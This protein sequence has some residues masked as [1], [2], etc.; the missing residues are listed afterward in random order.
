[1]HLEAPVPDPRELNPNIP[2]DVAFMVGRAMTKHPSS[3]QPSASEFY[4]ELGTAAEAGYGT[5]WESRSSLV[6]LVGPAAAAAAAAGAAVIPAVAGGIDASAADAT[7]IATPPVVGPAEQE[8]AAVAAAPAA[9][10]APAPPAPAAPAPPAT[11]VGAT[12]KR[13]RPKLRLLRFVLSML[14]AAGLVLGGI[15]YGANHGVLPTSLASGTSGLPLVGSGVIGPLT[16]SQAQTVSK[17]VVAIRKSVPQGQVR[18]TIRLVVVIAAIGAGVAILLLGVRGLIRRM[19]ARRLARKGQKQ[20]GKVLV[21]ALLYMVA[22]I[23]LIVLPLAA[24]ADYLW[25]TP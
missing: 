9:P 24:V 20:K 11:P 16:G 7:P 12:P 5:D 22:V 17:L 21:A 19:G 10:G 2:D 4:V 25:N 8:G 15:V 23:G 6:P 14:V 3:R 1:M 18:Q 13:V